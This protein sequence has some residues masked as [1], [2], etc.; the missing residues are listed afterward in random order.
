LPGEGNILI[1][2]NGQ[3]RPAEDYSSIEEILPPMESNGTYTRQPGSAYGPADSTWR[4][5]AQQPT[6]FYAI[7]LGSAQRLPNGN[8][9][10]CDGPQG[11]FFE[12]TSEKEVV[13]EYENQIPDP[14]DH[15]VFKV[16]R[17]APEYPGLRFLQ[18]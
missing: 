5:T 7:N 1:F 4:Y 9:L 10:I 16:F 11:R 2:N 12:V 18:L 14:I 17:Y 13:W 8:T 3:D 6:D 15:H